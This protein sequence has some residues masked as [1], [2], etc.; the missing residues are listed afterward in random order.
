MGNKTEIPPTGSYID[1]VKHTEPAILLAPPE[2]STSPEAALKSTLRRLFVF[3]RREELMK[4]LR[5]AQFT[6]DDDVFR[7]WLDLNEAEW[8]D[9][10]TRPTVQALP[11]IQEFSPEALSEEINHDDDK[12]DDSLSASLDPGPLF[13]RSQLLGLGYSPPPDRYRIGKEIARGGVGKVL[14]VR[15]RQLIRSQVIKLLNQGTAAEQK[16]VLNFIREA[17]ITAQLEHP[18]IVPVHDLGLLETGE[19]YFTMKRIR[20]QTLKEVLRSIR[21]GDADIARAFP[22]VRLLQILKSV[23]QAIAFAHSRGV[24]HR[25]LK[26]SNVMIGDFGEVLV[27]DWGIA[28]IFEGPE[29]TQPIRVRVGDGIKRSSVVGTPSYMSPE[30]A[31]G[32]TQRV[33]VTS[34]IYSLGAI[35]Y[36]I[37]TYRPPFR[38]KDARRLL[39]Q[40]IYEDPVPPRVFRPTLNIPIALEEI[41]MK[42]LS[43]DPDERYQTVQDL[44]DAV[45]HYLLRLEELDRRFRVAQKQ[46][47][48]AQKLIDHFK[49]CR[50]LKIRDEDRLLEEIWMMPPLAELEQRRTLWQMQEQAKDKSIASREAFREAERELREVT[51][52]YPPH[53]EAKSDLAYLYS[54]KLEEAKAAKDEVEINHFRQLL[55]TYDVEERFAPLLSDV[56]VVQLR[57]LPPRVTVHGSRGVEVDRTTRFLRE[58]QWGATPVNIRDVQSGSW[59]LRLS[60]GGYE[61]VLYPIQVSSGEIV[62]VSCR[63]YTKEELGEGF[64]LIPRG[65]FKMGGDPN[66]VSAQYVH[67]E[68][69]AD[70]AMAE[71]LVTCLDYLRFLNSIAL[72]NPEEAMRRSPRH[73]SLG[74]YLWSRDSSGIYKLP[75]PTTSMPWSSRWPVFGISFLDAQCYCQWLSEKEGERYRLPTEIEWEKAA[76]GLDERNYPWG[77]EFDPIFC[78]IAEGRSYASRPVKI[79]QHPKDLSPYGIYDL[80]GLVH[81]YCDTSFNRSDPNLK[82]LK[83]GSFQS[84]GGTES[85]ATHRMSVTQ[86]LAR[87]TAGFRIVKELTGSS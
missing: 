85:R 69:T 65:H 71:S 23:C 18:N 33:K 80:A 43:K 3:G 66:C 72:H 21:Q 39:E 8:I 10:F 49:K 24:L 78:A 17:Q 62:E 22:R 84:Y 52:L 83:G 32:K 40:A 41:A 60:K 25:D 75:A 28:K 61:D 20:G 87:F 67:Q 47:H 31:N 34:D 5:F 56:G 13:E 26:P 50:A 74:L 6:V 9:R 53:R 11:E 79:K 59:R 51:S 54:V 63:L 76:R 45:D 58:V 57:T 38:G 82:V 29:V 4:L 77:E 1:E 7:K 68:M 73:P 48:R 36:E 46:Y 70:I 19:V 12:G 2:D 64:R 27:L 86:T 44:I 16:V 42:C 81:E 14:R 15:D 37:L 30:Q 35:L 55:T